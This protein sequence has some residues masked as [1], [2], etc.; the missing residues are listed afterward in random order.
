MIVQAVKREEKKKEPEGEESVL[1]GIEQKKGL[2]A[3]LYKQVAVSPPV[4]GCQLSG[5]FSSHLIIH[6][7]K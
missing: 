4:A 6:T 7:P 2:F 5:S 3:V 1:F